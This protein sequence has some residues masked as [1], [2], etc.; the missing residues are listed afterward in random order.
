MQHFLPSPI[1]KDQFPKMYLFTYFI[2][3]LYKLTP[4]Q[5]NTQQQKA[6]LEKTTVQISKLIVAI[7]SYL[8]P[9]GCWNNTAFTVV[10]CGKSNQ[11]GPHLEKVCSKELGATMEKICCLN[12]YGCICWRYFPDDRTRQANSFLTIIVQYLPLL[13]QKRAL[14]IMT[15]TLTIKRI[16]FQRNMHGKGSVHFMVRPKVSECE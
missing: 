1:I 16:L 10:A 9:Q 13:G 15:S 7:G 14:K 11:T 4:I 8:E 6:K 12:C 2:K 3:R 5:N